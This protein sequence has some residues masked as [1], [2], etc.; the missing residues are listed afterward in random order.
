M[1][2]FDELPGRSEAERAQQRRESASGVPAFGYCALLIQE[3]SKG[4]VATFVSWDQ[5]RYAQR[6]R[7]MTR[8]SS[9][10]VLVDA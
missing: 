1:Q 10:A 7:G 4:S 8:R 2:A 9:L 6:K 3:R 5:K